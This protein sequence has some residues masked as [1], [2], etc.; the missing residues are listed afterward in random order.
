LASN[1]RAKE[2]LANFEDWVQKIEGITNNVP[3]KEGKGDG[4]KLGV[5]R[6]KW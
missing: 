5:I 3:N 4:K 6:K 1:W 2:S